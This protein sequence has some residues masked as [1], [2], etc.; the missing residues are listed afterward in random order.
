MRHLAGNFEMFLLIIIIL[1]LQNRLAALGQPYSMEEAAAASGQVKSGHTFLRQTIN[2]TVTCF[3]CSRCC[4]KHY[5]DFLY[6]KK[7]VR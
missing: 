5:A 2:N 1:L 7:K 3:G 6:L 4:K